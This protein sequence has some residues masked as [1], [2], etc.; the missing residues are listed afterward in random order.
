MDGW[1]H[2][3]RFME[4]MT[5]SSPASGVSHPSCWLRRVSYVEGEVGI[6]RSGEQE[7][8]GQ[9]QFLMLE[10]T[11]D[12]FRVLWCQVTAKKGMGDFA[13]EV[14]ASMPHADGRAWWPQR[15]LCSDAWPRVS[16]WGQGYRM[17]E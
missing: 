17:Y 14:S 15:W 1:G 3:A 5:Q 10:S 2:S 16:P 4:W 6:A 13:F 9:A 7:V 12:I 8:G 11:R